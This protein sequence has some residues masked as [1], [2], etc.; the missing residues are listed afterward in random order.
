[1][2]KLRLQRVRGLPPGVLLVSKAN[3]FI[4]CVANI[5]LV[6]TNSSFSKI[7]LRTFAVCHLRVL[8]PSKV[9]WQVP[10]DAR[11]PVVQRSNGWCC[12]FKDGGTSCFNVS[13]EYFVGMETFLV[14][15][16]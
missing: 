8:L 12:A 15:A 11:V 2:I 16:G 13:S 4:C 6:Y 1:M 3:L 5:F 14:D 10:K 9:N 7:I